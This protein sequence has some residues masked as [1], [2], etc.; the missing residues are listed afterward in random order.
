M[1]ASDKGHVQIVQ[2]LVTHQ[3]DCELRDNDGYTAL[4]KAAFQGHLAVVQYLVSAGANL[5]ARL[6][7]S[8][9]CCCYY[10]CCYYI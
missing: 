7:V 8:C 2:S 9:Y 10:C 1:I 6:P 3:A 5:S 4:L